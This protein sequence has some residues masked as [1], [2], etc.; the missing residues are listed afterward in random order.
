ME[1]A[2]LGWFVVYTRSRPASRFL[3]IFDLDGVIFDSTERFRKSLEEAGVSEEEFKKDHRKRSRVWEI[4]LSN[5]YLELDKPVQDALTSMERAY[6]LGLSAVILSGRPKRM[7]SKT[8]EMLDRIGARYDLLILR[9]DANKEKD[10]IYKARAMRW[11]VE[12]EYEVVEIHDDS[13]EVLN[14]LRELAPDAKLYLW[15]G[16]RKTELG[17]NRRTAIT[18]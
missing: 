12:H 1:V 16:G 4:F 17:S 13:E 9:G 3:A 8:I 14:K 11:L 15:I 10:H 2:D 5:K 6:M 18:A 7:A